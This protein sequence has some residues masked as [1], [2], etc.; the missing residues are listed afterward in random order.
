MVELLGKAIEDGRAKGLIGYK[1]PKVIHAAAHFS[2]ADLSTFKDF[3]DLKLTFDP[4]RNTFVTLMK[5]WKTTYN[6]ESNNRH[7]LEVYLTDTMLLAPAKTSLAALGDW[8]G[9]EKITLPSGKIEHMDVL[10][11]DDPKLFREYAI[12]DAEIA[13][14]HAWRM[15]EFAKANIGL[16]KAPVTL[17]G[18]A[19][20][21]VKAL[22]EQ[23][24][25]S[26]DQVL[27][28]K[29]EW[30]LGWN[31]KAGRKIPRK[32]KVHLT[33]VSD[34]QAFASECYHG[35]RNEAYY[36]GFTPFNTWTDYDLAGAYTTAMA[37]I[38]VPDY[39][40]LYET[41]DA[42]EFTT[43]VLGLA[44]I[45]FQF[46]ES[47]RFPSLPVRYTD[48]LI[49]PLSGETCVASP[50]I[51][52][53]LAMGA[54]LT[55]K[56]GIIV[57]WKSDVRP[58]ELFAK[59]IRDWRA[60]CDKASVE[61][62]TW[63][64]IGNSLYGKVAQGLHAKRESGESKKLPPSQVTQPFLAAYITSLVR[65]VLGEILHRIP[66]N[67]LVV[68]ATTDGFLTNAR[69]DEL[70]LSGPLCSFFSDLR[71]RIGDDPTILED[72]RTA[73]QLLCW[74]TRG[75]ATNEQA[76]IRLPPII[77][78]AGI[79]LPDEGFTGGSDPSDDEFD[80]PLPPAL[81]R[82]LAQNARILDLFLRRTAGQMIPTKWLTS[83]REMIEDDA[84]LVSQVGERRLP[85][86]FDWKRE[87]IDAHEQ[88]AYVEMDAPDHVA[89]NS[90]PWPTII[91]FERARTEFDQWHKKQGNVLKTMAD[92]GSWMEYRK[93]GDV[94]KQGVRRGRNGILD[95]VKR[96]FLRAYVNGLWGLPG[97]DYKVI[98]AF[99]T[100]RGHETSEY[101]LKNAK[102]SKKVP[103]EHLVDADGGVMGFINAVL[104]KFPA[105]EWRRMIKPT[106]RNVGQSSIAAG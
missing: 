20:R 35:G 9:L 18:L 39:A 74:R 94:S 28:R 19:V 64:E 14:L 10:L 72:K 38:K 82:D 67:R 104:E 3:K 54:T 100:E 61:E 6:D 56:R 70:D 37:G 81:E 101:D 27:G 78:K 48:G 93:S 103:V 11:R 98:A 99:L 26:K 58:F 42:H 36:F 41:K 97:D 63:K 33:D 34:Y 91:E 23:Q 46:P 77:A 50:E 2:R 24:G 44:R 17:G 40:R 71:K 8:Y 96:N 69:E 22:W 29:E 1:W 47:T 79:S 73:S 66:T 57:P 51:E 59:S 49:F 106:T 84:D 15:I 68:S 105:F 102:R 86:E 55:I 65:A 80:E 83:L 13:A 32:K 16:E 45:H 95:Q 43:D 12:R 92:W 25:I 89:A 31:E 62:R 60:A 30:H 52:L 75:Q 5:A 21:H 4:V 7:P 53:A 87:L 85:M 76:G 90:R 88:R